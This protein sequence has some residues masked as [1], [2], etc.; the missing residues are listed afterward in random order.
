MLIQ[1]N[2]LILSLSLLVCVS[3]V[4]YAARSALFPFILGLV[5]A[6]LLL[7]LVNGLEGWLKLRGP[8]F[9]ARRSRTLSILAIYGLGI[10]VLVGV[11]SWL[12]PIIVGEINDLWQQ[13]DTILS[14]VQ[15]WIDDLSIRFGTVEIPP[16]LRETV[17]E[18]VR[19]IQNT[20][21][22]A[23]ERGVVR[24]FLVVRSTISFLLGMLVVPFWVFY[25]LHDQRKLADGLYR[26]IPTRL[27]PDVQNLVML[28]NSILSAYIRGQLLLGLVIGVLSTLALMLLGVNYALL[29]GIVAG[30]FELIPFIGP[31]LSAIPAIALAGLES[32][33]LAVW[34]ALAFILI[35]QAE[36][37]LLVPKVQGESVQLHPA[38]IMVVLVVGNELLGLWGMLA[39]VPLTAILRDVFH[40]IYLR[41][42]AEAM[43]PEV[44]LKGVRSARLTLDKTC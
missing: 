30:F 25:V 7:P 33:Q 23:V 17:Y 2:R 9:V 41:L 42:G 39:A 12:V 6:Y 34:T 35:Q 32:P 29:L 44:A 21:V 36:S 4:L 5:L 10:G 40:Y 18:N 1:R 26:L 11:M 3:A 31:I 20:V 16:A 14:S 8:A 15:G 28:A 37:V 22:D 43:T 38:A 24:T 19:R 27:R 13:R